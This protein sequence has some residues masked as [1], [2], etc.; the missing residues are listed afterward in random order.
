MALI[1]L[2]FLIISV[3]FICHGLAGES[4]LIEGIGVLILILDIFAVGVTLIINGIIS[5]L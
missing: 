2:G 5:L 4:K 1:F 3:L